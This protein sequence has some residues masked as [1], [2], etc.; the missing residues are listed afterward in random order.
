ML[1]I[2]MN[3]DITG[4]S[5][6]MFLGLSMKEIGNFLIMFLCEV[7]LVAFFC[8]WLPL[9]LAV[10]ISVPFVAVL[11][12]SGRHIGNMNLK[13]IA[14]YYPAYRRLKRG[15]GFS[16]TESINNPLVT[17]ILQDSREERK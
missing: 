14:E 1:K 5:E 11:G 12:L 2:D 15:V 10:Y 3:K 17:Q 9:I 4:Y 13:E 8:I 16:S 7:L 6:G